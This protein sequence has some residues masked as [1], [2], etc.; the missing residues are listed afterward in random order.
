MGYPHL[1]RGHEQLARALAKQDPYSKS[2]LQW[3]PLEWDYLAPAVG[4]E[5]VCNARM[6]GNDQKARSRRRLS[7]LPSLRS[8]QQQGKESTHEE[9]GTVYYFGRLS[10]RLS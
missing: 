9:V 2:L 1:Q 7:K 8:Y 10:Y 4:I 5:A 6:P 3:G